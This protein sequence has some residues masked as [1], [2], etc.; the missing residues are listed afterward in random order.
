[1][2]KVEKIPA[3][4]LTKVRNKKEV[5]DE[6]RNKR[7]KDH[8]KSLMDLSSQEFG[9]RASI[10]KIQRSSR[11]PRWYCERWF[12]I[13]RSIYWTRIISITGDCSKSHGYHIRTARLRWTSSWRSICKNSGKKWETHQRYWKFQKSECPDIWIR[14]LKQ[15][16][17][18]SWS[19]MEDPV[20]P[21]ERNLYSHF[22]AGLSVGTATRESSIEIRLGNV[23]NWDSTTREEKTILVSVCWLA[24]KQQNISPTWKIL[25]KGVDVGRTNIIPWPCLFGLHSKRMSDK[26]GYL[27]K[28]IQKCVRIKDFCRDK[29][30]KTRNKATE[31]PDAE[32]TSSWSYDMAGD[33]KKCVERY[34]ELARIKQLSNYTKS[35]RHAWMI[36]NLEKK[37]SDQLEI[38]PQ[39]AHKLFWNVYFWLVLVDLIFYGLWTNLL[40]R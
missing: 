37:K 29:G 28:I 36:I 7:R 13:V 25:M 3:W 22:L 20:V 21:L 40:V 5:T 1:M 30:K 34:C 23:P 16:W 4:Q 27:W 10:S 39:F 18:K 31:N 24:G 17:L 35:R 15:K 14:L 19:S 38:C 9:A 11:S 32:T 26:Q 8:F 2:G 6:A 33:A 12:R